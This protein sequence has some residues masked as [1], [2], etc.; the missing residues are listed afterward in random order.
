MPPARTTAQNWLGGSREG[1]FTLAMI[2]NQL[3]Y[4][5][6][7]EMRLSDNFLSQTDIILDVAIKV[8]WATMT[9]Q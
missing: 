4:R 3:P 9:R 2:T 1:I 7:L 6:G 8:L 5:R